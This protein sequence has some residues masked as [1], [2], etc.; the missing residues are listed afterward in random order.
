MCF[1]ALRLYFNR[2]T[3]FTCSFRSCFTFYDRI[4]ISIYNWPIAYDSLKYLKLRGDLWNVDANR[5]KITEKQLELQVEI[6]AIHDNIRE[7]LIRNAI[8]SNNSN[9]N[10]RKLIVLQTLW[11]FEIALSF[12][13]NHNHLHQKFESHPE[14]LKN[15]PKSGDV[16][17]CLDA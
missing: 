11:K 7:Y 12:A 5:A 4:A 16:Y 6:N 9:Q 1:E 3:F 13:F 10:R 2:R 15:L 14:V 17:D 8:H